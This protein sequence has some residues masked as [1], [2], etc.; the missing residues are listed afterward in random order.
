[1]LKTILIVSITAENFVATSWFSSN[2][3]FNATKAEIIKPI[4]AAFNA[5]PTP[6]AAVFIF[7][8]PFSVPLV[9]SLIDLTESFN[10]SVFLVASLT[11]LEVFTKS[12]DKS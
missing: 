8:K 5:A 6:T 3:V 2:A 7:L 12:C 11:L 1:L 9:V 4:P 10:N